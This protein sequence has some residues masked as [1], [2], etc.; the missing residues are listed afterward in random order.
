[1]RSLTCTV[2]IVI[3]LMLMIS[4]AYA[5][6]DTRY[7]RTDTATVNGLT[8]EQLLTSQSGTIGSR[9]LSTSDPEWEITYVSWGCRA[10]ARFSNSSES[11]L[12]AGTP[13]A[14]VSRSVTGAG[15]QSATWTLTTNVSVPVDTSV[16]V[17]AYAAT[18][19]GSYYWTLL[20]TW[21]TGRLNTTGPFYINNAT[22]GLTYYTQLVLISSPVK[23]WNQTLWFDN[24]TYLFRLDTFIH[25]VYVAPPPSGSWHAV[26]SWTEYLQTRTWRPVPSWIEYL[27]VLQEEDAYVSSSILL[28]VTIAA[29][30]LVVVVISKK[31]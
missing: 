12:T 30:V 21:Q 11:E 13:I 9:N 22:W 31:R 18:Y 15:V 1:M 2:L 14:L 5:T 10:W 19:A 17:R 23:R 26:L 27:R 7:F 24:S 29:A 4:S 16:V 8:T 6:T 20:D 3:V 25:N 28:I